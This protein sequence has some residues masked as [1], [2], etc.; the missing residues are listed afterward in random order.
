MQQFDDLQ[1]VEIGSLKRPGVI[2]RLVR[3]TLGAACL[4]AFY[5]VMENWELILYAPVTILPEFMLIA[6]SALCIVN[7]VV[8]I[9][10]G[11]NWGIYPSL[12]TI[13][14]L[15]TAG[16]MAWIVT[17]SPNHYFLGFV[18]L[19]WLSYFYLHLGLSFVIAAAIATPGC[20]MR[21][22][23]E[24]FGKFTGKPAKEH[25]CPVSFIT[26]IDEWEA[27]LT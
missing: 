22:L 27:T 16:S 18:L 14:T 5:H 24:L 15:V 21:S 19:L 23:P 8:N 17:G 20:E 3:L 10:F 11:R 7:Y 25:Q 9:G 1:L 12:V 26:R 2:G 4:F 6:I 13:G